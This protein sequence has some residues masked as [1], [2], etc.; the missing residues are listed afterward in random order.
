MSLVIVTILSLLFAMTMSVVAWR[1]WSAE[2]RRSE[3]RIAHLGADIRGEEWTPV[4]GDARLDS[5]H[6][7][8]VGT[9]VLG[10]LVVSVLATI[11][12]V[13]F[14][15]LWHGQPAGPAAS[16]SVRQ[17]AAVSRGTVRD[18]AVETGGVPLELVALSHEREANRL[19]VRGVVRNPASG[20]V[21]DHLIAVVL[22]F[23]ADGGFITGTRAEV[24]SGR[25]APGSQTTFTATVP[26]AVGVGRYRVSFRSDDRIVPHVDRRT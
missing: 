26:D 24:A 18:A 20:S 23:D 12:V 21:R 3:A 9:A 7:G 17:P 1:A 10:V 6:F 4:I 11:V 8:P 14:P 19:T 15:G 25:L 5:T 16:S 22:L 13:V 2:R